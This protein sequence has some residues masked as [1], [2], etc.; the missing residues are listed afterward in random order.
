MAKQTSYFSLAKAT[1]VSR[2]HRKDISPPGV[3]TLDNFYLS[4]SDYVPTLRPNLVRYRDDLFS[5]TGSFT[6]AAGY[7]ANDFLNG[8]V[9]GTDNTSTIYINRFGPYALAADGSVSMMA[10]KISV[11]TITTSG[12]T[13]TRTGGE[14]WNQKIWVGCLI[15]GY[16]G[17]AWTNWYRV[18]EVTDAT[19]LKTSI[20]MPSLTTKAFELLRCHD[21]D[22]AVYPVHFDFLGATY[23]YGMSPSSEGTDY[24]EGSISGPFYSVSK[25][26]GTG[27]VTSGTG[28][29][30]DLKN[31][32]PQLYSLVYTGTEFLGIASLSDG[33][34]YA[35]AD[36]QQWTKR[37]TSGWGLPSTEA[38][39]VAVSPDGRII[40]AAGRNAYT[41]LVSVDGGVTTAYKG[42]TADEPFLNNWP[43][44]CAYGGGKFVV[45]CQGCIYYS[46]DAISWTKVSLSGLIAPT[47]QIDSICYDGSAFVANSWHATIKSTDGVT[48]TATGGVPNRTFSHTV[49]GGGLYMAFDGP[50]C[51][52]SSDAITWTY[53]GYLRTPPSQVVYD[54]NILHKFLVATPEYG[55]YSTTDGVSWAFLD[56]FGGSAV[57]TSY[58]V[59]CSSTLIVLDVAGGAVFY[60][61][62]GTSFTQV[63]PGTTLTPTACCGDNSTYNVVA[64][65]G[66][67]WA[68]SSGSTWN[69][70][71]SSL[72]S[73]TPTFR[74]VAICNNRVVAVGDTGTIAT[75]ATGTSPGLHTRTSGVTTTLRGATWGN[76]LFVVVGN[77][78]GG[79]STILTSP[80]ELVWTE[81]VA[82][83]DKD[84]YGVVWNGAKY[85][86]VGDTGII[87]S[88]TDGITWAAETS[89][90]TDNLRAIA[91][92]G[93]GLLCAVGATGKILTSAGAGTWTVQTSGTTANLAAVSYGLGRFVAVGAGGVAVE[94]IDGVTWEAATTGTTDAFLGVGFVSGYCFA[95][96]ASKL[97]PLTLPGLTVV[98]SAR[99]VFKPVSDLYRGACF[100]IG[101]GYTMLGNTMEW[102]STAQVY[103]HYPRRIRMTS[104]GT[105]DDFSGAGS[106]FGDLSGSGEIIDLRF[107]GHTFVS[108]ESKGIGA[109]DTTG[110]LTAPISY[111]RIDE[112]AQL[113]SNPCVAND[114]IY[115]IQKDGLLYSTNGIQ[116]APV[117]TGFDAT[118]YDDFTSTGPWQLVWDSGLQCLIAMKPTATAP[119]VVYVI[120]PISGSFSTMSLSDYA[121][122]GV[123]NYPRCLVSVVTAE[124]APND[125]AVV[126]PVPPQ[127]PVSLAFVQQPTAA[128][129]GVVISPAVTVQLLD[130]L[131]SLSAESGISVTLAMT[132]GTGILSGTLTQSTVSGIATFSD[133][134]VDTAGTKNITATSSGLTSA[135]SDAFVV[136]AAPLSET[137]EAD[138]IGVAPTGWTNLYSYLPQTSDQTVQSFGG[139]KALYLTA[140]AFDV[141]KWDAPGTLT[142][143][144]I[145]GQFYCHSG[146]S[147]VIGLAARIQPALGLY[148]IPMFYHA[149]IGA[150]TTNPLDNSNDNQQITL[151]AVNPDGGDYLISPRVAK[152]IAVDTA[153]TIRFKLTGTLLQVRAWASAGVEPATWD[154]EVTDSWYSSGACGVAGYA[155]SSQVFSAYADN[156]TVVGS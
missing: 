47:E 137:F 54:G 9:A 76:S 80:D 49:Y 88:S 8:I 24:P 97:V 15:R 99:A 147:C 93:S 154:I 33:G 122:G 111:R 156:L 63:N 39:S 55:A 135:V 79:D 92:D 119:H 1:A 42:G 23:L 14:A 98:T 87:L 141:T 35:S 69:R 134:S 66:A 113:L 44:C 58:G 103:N 90:V 91:Y 72:P 118:E 114:V 40:V 84:L 52:T 43:A 50:L 30:L 41:I 146:L 144:D 82:G 152:S 155:P 149:R 102:D 65:A 125:T 16:T 22:R 106:Y 45:G 89:G 129:T 70:D 116:V 59:A 38:V 120:D 12:T 133:L 19:T 11:G 142:D 140:K 6:G 27:T 34:I 100:A 62:N 51:Y 48:W 139:S 108:F 17:S 25:S 18:S 131:G 21:A 26:A 57:Y 5:M 101:D 153:Y 151:W 75:G 64:N 67:I 115:F 7:D 83:V 94:S 13:V 128:N 56:L 2:L 130:R 96:T 127:E 132:T 123:T 53:K 138:T 61:S 32:F 36:G 74:G 145:T 121:S 148:G 71:T 46:T 136:A 95:L 126:P 60:S 104:P 78:T 4:R 107:I 85:F 112:S 20:A 10:D 3:R 143:C 29:T 150:N 68:S 31:S 73:S 124:T 86:A 28:T 37:T 110:D 105:Y 77:T 81:R 117:G 109:M